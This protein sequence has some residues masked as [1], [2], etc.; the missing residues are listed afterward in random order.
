MLENNT[1]LALLAEALLDPLVSPEVVAHELGISHET[2]YAWIAR[3]RPDLLC[4]LPQR[5]RKRR[6]YGSRRARKQ[7]WTKYIRSIEERASEFG[8]EGD[9]IKGST[10]ARVLTHVDRESLF[11][12][13]DLMKDGTADSV[14]AVLKRH[15]KIAGTVTYDRGSEFALWQ[16]IER[17]TDA[18]IF[19]AHPQHPCERGKNE[20]TNGRLRRVF[21]KRFDLSTISQRQLD[22]VTEL[23]NHTPRK[24]LSWRTSCAV[25][26]KCCVSD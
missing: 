9:T 10:R 7:G 19:F 24:S 21:P 4:C 26:G 23:M 12:V 17:D 1:H 16:M 13:A 22:G 2:I 20:N 5:G 18:M 8:W 25:Y 11:T 6:R 3:S 15:Q 14:H